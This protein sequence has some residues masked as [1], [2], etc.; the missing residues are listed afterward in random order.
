MVNYLGIVQKENE[1]YGIVF[2][3]FAGCVSVGKNFDEVYKNGIEALSLH[4]GEMEKDGD[5]I[6]TPRD[7]DEIKNAKEDWYDFENAVVMLVPYITNQ[8]KYVRINITMEQ[9]LLNR[10]DTITKNRSAFLSNM[11]KEYLLSL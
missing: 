2:P 8:N 5:K 11:A 3:D 9:N 1:N 7:I 6:P 4:I 10:I